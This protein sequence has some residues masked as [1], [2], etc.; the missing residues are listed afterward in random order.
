MS[1]SDNLIY[2]AIPIVAANGACLMCHC[3]T[4]SSAH[5]KEKVKKR[6]VEREAL[7]A[8]APTTA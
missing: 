1:R 7:E 5:H 4:L 6:V 2:G 8:A 3:G